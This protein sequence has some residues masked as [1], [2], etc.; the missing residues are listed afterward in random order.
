MW[1]QASTMS[2]VSPEAPPFFVVHG[3]NDSLVPVEQARS[4]VDQLRATSKEPVVYAELPGAQHT[5]EVFDSARTLFTVGAVQ[6]FLDTI[7]ARDAAAAAS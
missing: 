1:E 3:S 4:F 5:F 2:W 7:V 6:R